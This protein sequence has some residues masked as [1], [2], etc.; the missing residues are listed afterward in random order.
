MD[1]RPAEIGDASQIA[2]WLLLPRV[3]R[4]LSSNLRGRD[5]DAGLVR[6]ALRR[7]DQRWYLIVDGKAAIGLIV[8]DQIDAIDGVANVW[9]LIG[10][11]SYLGQ[12]YASS[13]L[14]FIVEQNPLS[15]HTVT[16]WI[17]EINHASHR[18]L[19]KAGFRHIGEISE[20]FADEDGRCDRVLFEKVVASR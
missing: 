8:F 18:C 14:R 11:E 17:A 6:A 20:A 5:L 12:G 1:V 7:P 4:Y 16:A 9:Y 3:R 15:L 19:E 2:G 10:E 13:A